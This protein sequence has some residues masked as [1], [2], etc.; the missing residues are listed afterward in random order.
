MADQLQ[1]RRGNTAENASFTGADGEVVLDTQKHRLIVHDGVEAGGYPQATESR[2]NNAVIFF[3]DDT[4]AGSAADAYILAGNTNTLL[5]DQYN[6][7]QY[8]GFTTS[9]INTGA[10]T[11]NFNGLGVKSIKH[12][13]GE[14]V[15]AG[16]IN[17]RVVLLYD[18]TNDWLEIQS[19]EDLV[20]VNSQI[21]TSYT[22]VLADAG[23][24][25]EMDNASANTLTVPPYSSVKFPIGSVIVVTQKGAG[26]TTIAEGAGVSIKSPGSVKTL[27]VKDSSASLIKTGSDT[28]LMGGDL[29]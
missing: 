1:I 9:N 11:A 23:K 13:D 28:W 26:Q 3:D 25:I 2:L 29:G 10:A 15:V 16:E 5:P 21:G 22:A 27:R 4:G 8:L 20:R 17:G 12:A 7:G 19:Q 24:I 14:D 6:D 18:A